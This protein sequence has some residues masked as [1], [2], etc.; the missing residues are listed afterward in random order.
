[1]HPAR[2]HIEHESRYAHATRVATSKHLAC[3]QPRL[4]PRQEVRQFSIDVDPIPADVASATDYFGNTVHRFTM[5][6]PYDELVV[7]SRSIVDVTPRPDV[8][9]PS[10][11]PSWEDVRD[12]IAR[13]PD[14]GHDDV[15]EFSYESPLVEVGSKLAEFAGPSLRPGRPVLEAAW[16][17]MRRIHDGFTFD[18]QATTVATPVS[19]VLADRHGV[20]QDF[21]HLQIACLRSVGLAARYVSGYL[22]TDPPE[23]QARLVG[24]DAS[25]AWLSIWCPKHGWVDLDPTNGM[26]P[27]VRHVT[28]AWGRDYGDVSPLKG[29][30]LGGGTQT[31][32]V[33]V[34]VIPEPEFE[35]DMPP[36]TIPF[37]AFLERP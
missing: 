32:S 10:E 6:T 21:A 37:D 3:L 13:H 22:L 29:V 24:A 4:L 7:T 30:V 16:D 33:G 2:Y 5:L 18:N 19:K 9:I 8:I 15:L 26:V 14:P 20:C 36:Q 23:G 34:S 28:I 25:H 1:M 35:P 12:R 17:L 27:D 11:S 31:L